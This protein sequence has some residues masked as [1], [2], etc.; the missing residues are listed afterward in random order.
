MLAPL[1]SSS[2]IFLVLIFL[3]APL[4]KC[5][6]PNFSGA[7]LKENFP[8]SRLSNIFPHLTSQ[9]TILPFTALILGF[10]V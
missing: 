10:A 2:S 5:S 7:W 6:T 8:T 3:S 9:A 4:L 1:V